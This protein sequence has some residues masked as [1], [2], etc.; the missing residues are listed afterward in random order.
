MRPKPP[1]WDDRGASLIEFAMVFII[2]L[3]LS[4]G[5]FE[6]GMA[7]RDWLSVSTATREGGRVAASAAN[8]E[9]ADCVVLEAT[10]GALQSF[11]SGRIVAATIYRSSETGAFPGTANLRVDYRPRVGSDTPV[12]QC[13]FWTKDPAGNGQ[14]WEPEDRVVPGADPHWI[15]VRLIFAHPWRTGFLWWDGE[16]TWT[17]DA[18]FKIEPPPPPPPVT[19]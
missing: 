7:F 18:V 5:A 14:D 11:E 8:Y 16:A 13:P 12:P 15:G 3:M 9:E 19:P 17:D 10:S 2:L 1:I 4:L 6:Y